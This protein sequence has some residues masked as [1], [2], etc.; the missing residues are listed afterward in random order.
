MQ[1]TGWTIHSSFLV[2]PGLKKEFHFGSDRYGTVN[3]HFPVYWAIF[4][5]VM[6]EQSTNRVILVQACS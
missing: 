6:N 3:N 2:L 5:M 4:G 1:K